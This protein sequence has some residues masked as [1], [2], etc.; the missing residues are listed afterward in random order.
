[1]VIVYEFLTQRASHK[2]CQHGQDP[3]WSNNGHFH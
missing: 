1:L 2:R 3:R